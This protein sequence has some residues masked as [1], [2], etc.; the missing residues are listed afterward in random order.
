[1]DVDEH[2]Q[3]N[4][5]APR[6]NHPGLDRSSKLS[7]ELVEIGEPQ[8]VE[9]YNMFPIRLGKAKKKFDDIQCETKKSQEKEL[10]TRV[11]RDIGLYHCGGLRF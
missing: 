7:D 11:G 5:A 8:S 2:H 10:C 3:A 9:E 4:D 6:E 1:V